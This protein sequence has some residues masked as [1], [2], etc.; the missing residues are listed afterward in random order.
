MEGKSTIDLEQS[1]YIAPAQYT[2]RY[3]VNEYNWPQVYEIY[4]TAI[5]IILKCM[6]KE[7]TIMQGP[8]ASMNVF[9]QDQWFRQKDL[10]YPTIRLIL[11]LYYFQNPSF[12][13]FGELVSSKGVR[14][15]KDLKD[16]I[17]VGVDAG[18]WPGDTDFSELRN[19]CE[20][21]RKKALALLE[22]WGEVFEQECAMLRQ[23]RRDNAEFHE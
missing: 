1:A 16:K 18:M 8:E 10:P 13:Q 6:H 23:K 21:L 15:R 7:I 5:G 20:I 4:G 9:L 2:S 22:K 14:K 3:M 11:D 19:A 17:K 12:Y